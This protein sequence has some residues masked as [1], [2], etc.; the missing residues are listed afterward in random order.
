MRFN[1][2][3]KIYLVATTGALGDTVATFP[4][5]K[6]LT[7]RG[8]IEKLFVDS[9]YIDLYHLFFPKEILVNLQDAMKMVPAN[10]IT[11]NVPRDAIDPTTGNAHYLDYPLNPN[12]PVVK[13]LQPL[14]TSIHSH[15]VD[16]FSLTMTD[17]ILKENM[18]DYPKVDA[19]KLPLNP[20]SD[21]AYAVVAYG[22]TTEHRKM[23]P[24][25]FDAIVAQ[26]KSNGLEVV[27]LGKRDHSL[28]CQGT[29]TKPTF[30]GVSFDDCINLI[31]QTTFPEALSIIN[32]A[33]IVVG[34]D[35]GL[36]HLAATTDVPIVVGYTT[37]DPYYR[38]PYRHEEKG[39]NC[40]V[41]EP[42]SEC[43]YC[44]T[45][46]FCAYGISFLRC[47][48]TTKECM[49]SLLPKLWTDQIELALKH[50]LD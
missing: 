30:E 31:D 2:R 3:Q 39:W 32:G 42:T 8:H 20:L 23:L 5:L 35:N 45:E 18:K 21:K 46:H 14:P 1:P 50:R 17:A 16:C 34:L 15:L 12:L 13:T 10:E 7:E 22:S 48:T 44:Q 36:I 28:N 19:S 40:F 6:I 27:L 11:P 9:R 4:T 26:L 24:E 25:A 43:C 38:L 37:V 33:E 29:M 49:Y 47:A 41:V